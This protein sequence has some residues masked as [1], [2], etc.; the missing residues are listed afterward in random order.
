LDGDLCIDGSAVSLSVGAT[1]AAR[2]Q[3]DERIND[4]SSYC[5]KAEIAG[6]A[7]AERLERLTDRV[8]NVESWEELLA[9]A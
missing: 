5:W 7:S 6:I 8:L 9:E 3:R 2:S 1:T 4:V